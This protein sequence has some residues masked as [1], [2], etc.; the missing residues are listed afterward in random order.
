MASLDRYAFWV[1]KLSILIP[2]PFNCLKLI[3][4]MVRPSS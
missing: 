4:R 3:G 2:Y 1:N